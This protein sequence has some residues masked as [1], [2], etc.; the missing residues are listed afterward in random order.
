MSKDQ[1]LN[2]ALLTLI[3][4]LIFQIFFAPKTTEKLEPGVALIADSKTSSIPNTPSIKVYNNTDGNYDFDTCRDLFI[5]INSQYITFSGTE[6]SAFCKYVNI[7]PH[8]WYYLPFHDIATFFGK[9]TGEYT[10][11]LGKEA[12][13]P[14]T[15]VTHTEQGL[16]G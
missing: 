4:T 8:G 15:T 1:I 6:Y 11:S 7:Q 16:I 12:T 13:S 9:K 2:L 10:V 5:R 3:F 14:T